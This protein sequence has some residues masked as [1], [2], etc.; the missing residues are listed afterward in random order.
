[1]Q[2]LPIASVKLVYAIFAR[3]SSAGHGIRTASCNAFAEQAKCCTG[4]PTR[5]PSFPFAQ[6]YA[7]LLPH[8][9][10]GR[11]ADPDL[12]D[13]A[14]G[15]ICREVLVVSGLEGWQIG[16]TRVFLRAG[17]LANIEVC[18]FPGQCEASRSASNRQCCSHNP[19]IENMTLWAIVKHAAQQTVLYQ[20]L[21]MTWNS[22]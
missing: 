11:A 1:M 15:Q 10:A 5:K 20:G 18:T 9:A 16:K 6:R 22:S 12:T 3:C 13:K 14:A 21:H 17:Q 2:R 4:F 7:I 8:G 19:N